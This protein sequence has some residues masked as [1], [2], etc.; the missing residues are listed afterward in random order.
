MAKIISIEGIDGAGKTSIL[1]FVEKKLLEMQKKVVKTREIGSDLVKTGESFRKI[2]LDPNRSATNEAIEMIFGA[3]RIENYSTYSTEYKDYDYIVSDRGLL[4]H[5]AYADASISEKFVQDFY[6]NFLEKY[7]PIDDYII[8]LSADP[9]LALSRRLKRGGAIDYIEKQGVDFQKK[10]SYNFN[11]YIKE[12][13]TRV[14]IFIVDA[15]QDV[16]KVRS[17]I[18]NVLSAIVLSPSQKEM[19]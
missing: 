7:V 4:S 8:Y 17:D 12:Y 19:K 10:V 9:D 6:I 14:P 1:H 15:N 16:Q 11:K 5:Y 13:K 2:A 18:E 3:M